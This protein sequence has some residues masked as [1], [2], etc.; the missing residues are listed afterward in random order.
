MS[1]LDEKT[2]IAIIVNV[3]LGV[4]SFDFCLLLIVIVIVQSSP[5]RV[6][7]DEKSTVGL[8]TV[9]RDIGGSW[10]GLA[11]LSALYSRDQI[12]PVSQSTEEQCVGSASHLCPIVEHFQVTHP[13]FP[14]ALKDGDW[15]VLHQLLLPH[16]AE[17]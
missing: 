7:G 17:Q 9:A 3:I 15:H 16:I 1:Y 10:L 8:A 5:C 13:P 6:G 4:I 11:H 2:E 14:T 12:L